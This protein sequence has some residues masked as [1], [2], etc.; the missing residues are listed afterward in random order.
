MTNNTWWIIWAGVAA[1][2]LIATIVDINA[3]KTVYTV[4]EQFIG[5]EEKVD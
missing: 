3:N 1:V 5:T 4:R 2:I